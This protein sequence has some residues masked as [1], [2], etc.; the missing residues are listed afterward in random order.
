MRKTPL[1]LLSYFWIS[2]LL[3]ALLGCSSSDG[4]DRDTGAGDTILDVLDVDADEGSTAE[5][6]AEASPEAIPETSTPETTPETVAPDGLEVPTLSALTTAPP[7]PA[8]P[9]GLSSCGVYRDARCEA[10]ALQRCALYDVEADAWSE[11]PPAMTEQAY[12]FDRY[13]DL[14]HSPLGQ[15]MDVRFTKTIPAGTPESEW[16]AAG[17][18]ERYDGYGDASGWS[19][20]ALLGAAARFQTSG[21]EADYERLLTMAE[22]VTFLYE[23]TAIPGLIARSHY[24]MLPEGA[25]A[26]VGNWNKA[27]GRFRTDDEFGYPI[28]ETL[29]ERVPA[30]YSEG[31]DIE[32][33]HY[34]TKPI[35][36]GDASRDMYVRGLPGVLLA[37]DLLKDDDRAKRVR[38]VLQEQLPCTIN[39][40]KKGRIRNLS[41]NDLIKSMV[42]AN[43]AG[44]SMDIDEEETAYF[45]ELD[46]VVFYVMEEPR[47]GE[48]QDAFEGTCPDGPPMEVD[49]EYDLDASNGAFLA[50][51]AEMAARE[52]KASMS[53]TPI[54][55]TQH[56]G[57]RGSDAVFMLQWALV[58][59]YV[60]QDPRY[61]DFVEQFLDEVEVETIVGT[62]G[63]FNFPKWCA[64]HFG[65]SLSYPS[66]YNLLGRID[67]EASPRFWEALSSAAVSDG[68]YKEM[69][70]RED[71]YFGILYARMTNETTDPEAGPW[72]Q[73]FV[74]L[75]KTY[76][77]H[78]LDEGLV[79]A[80]FEPDRNVPRNFIDRPDPEIPLEPLEGEDLAICT[81]PIVVSGIEIPP[82]RLE[83][84]WP[85]AIDAVPLPK[86]VGGA[87]LWQMDPWMVKREYGG[88]GMD[89]QWPMLGLTVPYWVGRM[90]KLIEEGQDLRLSWRDTGEACN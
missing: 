58:A 61:L 83:D 56:P 72:V 5:Q 2:A 65:P 47:V 69:G 16:S 32:G 46:T 38:E 3:L 63:S 68:R 11:A 76:G 90:D 67:P 13:Y 15:T 34:D 29:L 36:Q 7:P 82:P 42:T 9:A 51:L 37:Y 73:R 8:L 64:P 89:E 40:M 31:I 84:D 18:F 86:R 77:S 48:E 52:G 23:V 39:R 62:Y 26:P 35:W 87:F 79:E 30:Y 19:G 70:E 53:K 71:A 17:V 1:K 4:G 59:H 60:S 33:Q 45:E 10:G 25:P 55:W 43:V 21:S 75:L 57:L 27:V 12:M 22:H 74:D 54:A 41:A 80:K 44:A 49:P 66:F 20:T 24:A 81:E 85:R 78:A 6:L 88:I 28:D 50:K 14:Y